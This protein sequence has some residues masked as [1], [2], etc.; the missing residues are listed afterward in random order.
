MATVFE[1]RVARGTSDDGLDQGPV[2]DETF[3]ESARARLDSLF[4]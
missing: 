1:E 3:D 4:S 2:A